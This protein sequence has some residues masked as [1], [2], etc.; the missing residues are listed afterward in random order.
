MPRHFPMTWCVTMASGSTP[1]SE[2]I[3]SPG[4]THLRTKGISRCSAYVFKAREGLTRSAALPQA[5]SQRRLGQRGVSPP[6]LALLSAGPQSRLWTQL[7]RACTRSARGMYDIVVLSRTYARRRAS[8]LLR[9]APTLAPVIY[10]P[11]H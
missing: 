2:V 10:L 9:A 3:A 4:C 6:W 1:V 7:D 11:S 5:L 8:H